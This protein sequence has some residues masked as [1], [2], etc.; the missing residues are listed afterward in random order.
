MRRQTLPG[1][2]SPAGLFDAFAGRQRGF[3]ALYDVV[4]LPGER[5]EDE[6][7]EDDLVIRRALGEGGLAD[8]VEAGFSGLRPGMRLPFDQIVLRPSG[9]PSGLIEQPAPLPAPAPDSAVAGR[10]IAA[11][12][13]RYCTP[14][15]AG[16]ATCRG[17]PTPR[18]IRRV[19]IHVIAV[20]STSRRSGVAAV[21]AG[22]QNAGR[23]A[24]SHY[25][26][27]RDGTVTQM[28]R[29]ANVA[30][31][32]P[33]N[34][35]DSIG[36]EHADVCNDPAPLTT[37]LYER[38][39]ELVRDLAARHR[40]V[41]GNATVAGH[42]DVNPNH[43]DPGP[44]WDWE[45]YR[46]LL[47]WDG[48][49]RPSRPLRVVA[50]A[51][52]R[53]AA[54][55]GWQ[56][57][58]RRA[59]PNDHCAN[60]HDPWGARY[61]RAQPAATGAAAELI[62]VA[63]EPGV[64]SVSLWW[65]DVPGANPAVNVE[66][67]TGCISSPCRQTAG[68]QNATVNQRQG[69]GR[70]T[71][72]GTV[73]IDGPPAEVKVRIRR[74]SAQPGWILCDGARLL[75][76]A[77]NAPGTPGASGGPGE[78]EAVS[79]EGP[80]T[81]LDRFGNDSAALTAD[82]R[83]VLARLA[84]E[85]VESRSG[86][87]PV[88][89]VCLV[90]HADTKGADAYNLQLAEK[91]AANAEAE[92]RS[93]INALSPGLSDRLA[94][95]RSSRGESA[96]VASDAT[97][98]GRARNRRVEIS[99]RR[100]RVEPAVVT[101]RI[102]PASNAGPN[103]SESFDEAD[104]APP[105]LIPVGTGEARDFIGTGSPPPPGAP[106]YTW[107]VLDPAVARV[108]PVTDTQTHPNRVTVFGLKPGQ[109]TLRHVYRTPG[110]KTATAD[111]PI[112]I[113]RMRMSLLGPDGRVD[114]GAR[115]SELVRPI[116]LTNDAV[117][118]RSVLVQLEPASFFAGKKVEWT[119]LPAAGM[120]KSLPA[121]RS[122]LE[123][124]DKSFNFTPAVGRGAVG[125]VSIVD[126]DGKA[127]VRV[128]VP[129]V[130]FNRGR[131]VAVVEGSPWVSERA[132]L[133]VPGVVVI[134]PGHG[135]SKNHAEGPLSHTKEKDLALILGLRL[136]DALLANPRFVRAT[137]TRDCDI[138]IDIENR[139]LQARCRGADVLL[140]IHFNGG[141][142][143]TRGTATF[144][145]ADSNGNVN[146]NE[147]VALAR[148]VQDAVV[149]TLPG[150]RN[151]RD[152]GIFDDTQSKPKSLGV[153]ND[154]TFGNTREFHPVR[155]CLVEV[156]FLS[157]DAVDTMFNR[158]ANKETLRTNVA[159]AMAGAIVADLASQ[160]AVTVAPAPRRP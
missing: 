65:P 94:F 117:A 25:L 126:K 79:C 78:S 83:A 15:Q 95:D 22:W 55:A 109:T 158:A 64:Y 68:V 17:L 86:S 8:F 20:P 134:D 63:D 14:G 138:D 102:D 123:A 82:H 47:V 27:D 39:A 7:A 140:S 122:T 88:E 90:G 56:V 42:H 32:T 93:Q 98:E 36:I 150:G 125:G 115:T 24:S 49:T 50:A 44:Y 120:R 157:T 135:G 48:T 37:R 77:S 121:G 16:S 159:N 19:V 146:R 46:L 143:G 127:A 26:V 75:R 100:G 52:G 154:K 107:S 59:I 142:N 71:V 69:F 81:V 51:A 2:V 92:L 104:P 53:P 4:A 111:T 21:I 13:T 147:D 30:F 99:L 128:N 141:A 151:T 43:G 131:I 57:A 58:R 85:I 148:R 114:P 31:H 129:A 35:E 5:L 155:S 3:E 108:S 61:W 156:D 137:L 149:A 60:S 136:R 11:H 119:F 133:E 110:G 96:P 160:M 116:P 38:S 62:L 34:N 40:I 112:V 76:I 67:Q 80:A 45:Y 87:S 33:G 97:P 153:L 139:A 144:V 132:E 66:I 18:P 10:F 118:H 12:A 106:G 29:E 41:I 28:V 105:H 74:D 152:N 1:S 84:R 124:H 91:R 145:R 9:L 130:A 73:T 89:G 72:V 70:W 6:L 23:Q 103:A 113:A 54:P 101:A